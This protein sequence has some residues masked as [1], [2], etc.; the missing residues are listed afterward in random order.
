MLYQSLDF[1]LKPIIIEKTNQIISIKRNSYKNAIVFDLYL[2][3][4]L[5]LDVDLNVNSYH[6]LLTKIFSA[7]IIPSHKSFEYNDPRDAEIQRLQKLLQTFPENCR[8]ILCSGYT[9]R[10]KVLVPCGHTLYC[11]VCIIQLKKCN[12]CYAP[13]D[14]VINLI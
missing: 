4:E 1:S 7:S 2:D 8:C 14:H 3:Y 6:F 11:S 5:Y 9:D 10:R 12:I 13:I